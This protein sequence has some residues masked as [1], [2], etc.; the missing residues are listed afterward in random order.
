MVRNKTVSRWNDV[1]NIQKSAQVEFA[2]LQARLLAAV[3]DADGKILPVENFTA[4]AT[5]EQMDKGTLN[6]L[7]KCYE[8]AL[9]SAA[10]FVLSE[11]EKTVLKNLA[12]TE[13]SKL[14][15]KLSALAKCDGVIHQ[16]EQELIRDVMEVMEFPD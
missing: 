8:S 3:T 7:R 13:K 2:F 6:D 10:P 14:A 12:K 1:Y 5:I 9:D 16:K 4:E 11:P 15:G